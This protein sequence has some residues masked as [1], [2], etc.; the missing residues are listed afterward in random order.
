M[1]DGAHKAVVA[2]LSEMNEYN[3]SGRY[4]IRELWNYKEDRRATLRDGAVFLL[5]YWKRLRSERAGV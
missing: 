1:G 5:K 3:P 2:A 4:I